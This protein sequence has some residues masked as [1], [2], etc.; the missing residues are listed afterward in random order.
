MGC[1]GL[2]LHGMCCFEWFCGW[3]WFG[4]LFLLLLVDGVLLWFGL[5]VGVAA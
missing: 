2:M 1:A 5:L 3:F 4:C